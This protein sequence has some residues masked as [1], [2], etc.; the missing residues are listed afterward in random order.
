M[1]SQYDIT[2]QFLNGGVVPADLVGQETV[3][4]TY[5]D[6]K[7]G[8]QNAEIAVI[9]GLAATAQNT[10]NVGVS[11]AGAAQSTATTAV[12]AAG[13][14]QHTAEIAQATVDT[15]KVSTKAHDSLNITY[16]GP[17]SGAS[18]VKQALDLTKQRVDNIVA[19][20]GESNI[21]IVDARQ[22]ATGPAFPVLG[23]RLNSVDTQLAEKADKRFFD[24]VGS[25][26]NAINVK[27]GSLLNAIAPDLQ[28]CVI[29][30]GGTAVGTENVIGGNIAGVNNNNITNL[31]ILL[32]TNA[33]MS[34]IT[35]GYDNVNNGLGS[36]LSGHHNYIDIPATHSC[37][38]GGSGHKMDTGSWAVIAGGQNNQ[39]RGDSAN[40]GTIGGGATNTLDN[41]IG[42]TIGGGSTNRITNSNY[43]KIGGGFNNQINTSLSGVIGGGNGNS[44]LN[45]AGAAVL[46]GNTNKVEI[47]SQNAS[48]QGGL[49]NTISNISNNSA[50][51][52]GTLNIITTSQSAVIGGGY[53]NKVTGANYAVIPGGL[54][55]EVSASY[56]IAKGSY[57]KASRINEEAFANGKNVNVGDCQVTK[58]IMRWTS[59]TATLKNNWLA[60][61]DKH[62]VHVKAS[63][64]AVRTDVIG[65][66][67]SWEVTGLMRNTVTGALVGSTAVATYDSTGSLP[68]VVSLRWESGYMI[69]ETT[70]EEA[71]TINWLINVEMLEIK[72]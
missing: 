6:G 8:S 70:G 18:S 57:A 53:S 69:V 33:N 9:A 48:I 20:G 52:G 22:P 41:S 64:L 31:P 65:E 54:G 38:S 5:V 1:S 23:E 11:A 45:S 42:G 47:N 46:S 25:N 24:T 62:F 16:S 44:V 55:N 50:I 36:F 58:N 68:W 7:V 43:A 14:A 34:V 27:S 19:S 28:G 15:H 30:G 3:S 39:I 59:S 51:V 10:A 2:Q 13:V 40:N 17:V 67:K 66:C 12:G 56:G 71:K 32:G 37:I 61:V 63:V 21:E 72:Q 4:K 49:T 60:L 26:P 29:A 35:G